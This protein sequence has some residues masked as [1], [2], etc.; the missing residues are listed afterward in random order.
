MIKIINIVDI[1]SINLVY[2]KTNILNYYMHKK[3][4]SLFLLYPPNKSI[5]LNSISPKL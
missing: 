2:F 5:M 3:S 1:A 4:L